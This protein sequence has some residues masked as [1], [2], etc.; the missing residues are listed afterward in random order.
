V[1]PAIL[2]QLLAGHRE[3]NLGRLDTRRDLTFVT[4]TV[5]GFLRAATV[6]GIEGATI[7]L[8]T[9]RAYT[10]E[11]LFSAC[12]RV[13]EVDARPRADHRRLRPERS[14]VLHL[15]S[16]PSLAKETLGWVARE[17]LEG[18]L[19]KTAQWLRE[20]LD[21]FKPEVLHV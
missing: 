3:V 9:G 11:E 16:D 17:S 4:D 21:E 2:T 13:L 19:R 7:Q 5:E 14:E 10:I 8:G 18:G 6:T 20:H 12:C 1:L 15:L